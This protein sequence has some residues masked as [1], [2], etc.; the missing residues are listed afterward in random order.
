MISKPDA[1]AHARFL[2]ARATDNINQAVALRAKDEES[3]DARYLE[4]VADG[5]YGAAYCTLIRAGFLYSETDLICGEKSPSLVAMA[6]ERG[7][8]S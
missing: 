2:L 3:A 8:A 5:H 6:K 4:G 1:E 7:V